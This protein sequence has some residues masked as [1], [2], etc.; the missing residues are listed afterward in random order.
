MTQNSSLPVFP[1][2]QDIR[3][4]VDL[5]AQHVWSSNAFA[6]VFVTTRLTKPLPT[7][8]IVTLY[9]VITFS[10]VGN[11]TMVLSHGNPLA[12]RALNATNAPSSLTVEIFYRLVKFLSSKI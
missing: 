12:S 5:A 3:N 7:H 11:S 9:L 4:V 8:V 2:H 10:C 6:Y 1:R